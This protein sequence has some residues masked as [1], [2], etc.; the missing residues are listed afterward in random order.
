MFELLT[1]GVLLD[2]LE[3]VRV[4]LGFETLLTKVEILAFV[5]MVPVANDW[6]DLAAIAGIVLMNRYHMGYF[7]NHVLLI[8]ALRTL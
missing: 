6:L 7:L 2:F 4:R 5:A 8:A 3:G 1:F